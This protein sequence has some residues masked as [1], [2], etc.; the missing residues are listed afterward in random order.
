[1]PPTPYAHADDLAV[2]LSYLGIERAYLLGV[3]LGG[4]VALDFTPE[5]PDLVAALITSGVSIGGQQPSEMLQRAWV[6]IEHAGGLDQA[7][8]LELRLWVD[9]LGRSSAQVAPAVREQVRRVNGA[10]L[11]RE[12]EQERAEPRRLDPPAISRLGEIRI[13]LLAIVGQHDISDKYTA[14]DLLVVEV[15]GA[16]KVVM[17]DTAHVPSM[18]QPGVF[19]RLVFDFLEGIE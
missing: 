1:M 18:E 13:P 7:N 9:G 2:L 15:P 19:A 14:A 17:P 16:R 11:A 8:E 10:N 12:T 3:S 4:Q 6:E 5:H